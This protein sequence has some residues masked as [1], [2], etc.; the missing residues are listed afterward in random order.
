M[1]EQE[2]NRSRWYNIRLKPDEYNLLNGRFQKT[3]FRKLSEYMRSLLLEKPVTVIYRDKAM[4]DML[5]EMVL[6]RQELNAIGNNLNQAMRNINGAH[7]NADNRLWLNLL[8]VIN[9]KLEPA[10]KQIK[11]RMNQYA[12][13]WSQ[14]LKAAKA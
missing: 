2:D 4:D 3:Q 1:S 10:I 5:E 8:S 11:E 7:G 9:T 12:E 14:K 6:L 13:I